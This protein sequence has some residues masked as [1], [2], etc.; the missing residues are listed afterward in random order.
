MVRTFLRTVVQACVV[1][2]SLFLLASSGALCQGSNPFFTPPTFSGSGQAL[3]A[4][5]NGDGKPDLLFFDGTVLLSK[6]DGTFTTGTPWKSSVTLTAAQFAIADFNGD[7]KPDILVAGPLNVLSV[8]FGRGDGTFQTPVKTTIAAPATAFV[9]GDLNGDGKPDVLAKVG[10]TISS[11]LGK[12]DGTFAAGAASKATDASVSDSFADFNHDGKLDLFIPGQGVQLGS[13]DGTFQALLPFPSGA[14]P[15]SNVY[16][17]FNGDA[18]L[19][20][21]AVGGTFESPQLQ[22][23]FGNGDGTF[24][25]TPTVTLP[26]NTGLGALAIGDMNG[27][28][29]PDLVGSSASGSV[30]V[31]I[32]K[33]DGTFTPG[34]FYNAP[35]NGPSS[36]VIADFNNDGKEDVAALIREAIQCCLETETG[37]FKAM[38]PIQA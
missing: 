25:S 17:D 30:Q 27:D 8:S 23:L 37:R 32:G 38:K 20:V 15:G 18:K 21:A 22:I 35:T 33:G 7:G 31:L 14:L 11:Y 3:S 6:G 1:F 12:G 4:D 16:A 13:G 9:V 36:I 19:D 5:V 28:G 26:A 2:T 10:S 24:R 29:K 34:T